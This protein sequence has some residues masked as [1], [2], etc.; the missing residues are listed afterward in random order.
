VL[1]RLVD[2]M[3][4]FS[5]DFSLCEKSRIF[6]KHLVLER[7]VDL[8]KFFF[9]GFFSLW[10]LEDFPY[11]SFAGGFSLRIFCC[12]LVDFLIYLKYFSADFSPCENSKIFVT[13]LCAIS[14][15]WYNIVCSTYIIFL[16]IRTKWQV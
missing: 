16:L 15:Y 4:Y 5:A 1:E 6:F 14:S 13:Y 9:R 7:L 3:K 10:K 11:V 2:L 12:R 8:L